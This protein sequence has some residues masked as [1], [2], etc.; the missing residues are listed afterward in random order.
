MTTIYIIC[1]V[2]TTLSAA[3]CGA[4]CAIYK[5]MKLKK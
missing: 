3:T 2:V 4:L 1:A 5:H